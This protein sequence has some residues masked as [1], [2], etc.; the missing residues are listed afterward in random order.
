VVTN[1]ED[2]RAKIWE[3]RRPTCP[4]KCLETGNL[5]LSSSFNPY[6]DQLILFSADDG[7]LSLF[8]NAS[9]SSAPLLKNSGPSAPDGLVKVF[10]EHDDSVH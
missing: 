1:G 3:M 4:V 5:I 8:R 10:D 6:H 2:I 7:S 9:T